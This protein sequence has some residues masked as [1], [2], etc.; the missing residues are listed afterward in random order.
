MDIFP[1][2]LTATAAVLMLLP[3]A[4]PGQPASNLIPLRPLE[5][6][7]LVVKAPNGT[8][9]VA[10][11]NGRGIDGF[12]LSQHDHLIASPSIAVAP[13][14]TI[15]VAFLEQHRTTYANAIY[16]RSSADGGKTWTE[17][18][19]LTEDSVNMDVG[20]CQ[21][22][23]DAKNRVYVIWR[24]AVQGSF[25]VA[26]DL[27]GS[28]SSLWYRVLEAGKWS[29][30]KP[31]SE[32]GTGNVSYADAAYSFF[33][34]V[35]EA[36]RVQVVW[37]VVPDKRHPELARNGHSNGVGNGLVL[38]STLDGATASAPR[39]VFMAAVTPPANAWA[40]FSCDGLDTL[41]GYVDSEGAAHFV[42][43]AAMPMYGLPQHPARYELIEKGKA[44]ESI[45]LPPLSFHAAKDIPTLLLD[46]KGKRHLIAFYAAGEHPNI[47][48]YPLGSEDEPTVIRAAAGLDG[49][50]DGFQACQGSGGRMVAI[51]QMN[52]TGER[53]TDENYVS[54]STG[55]GKWSVP[56]NVSNN[57]GRKTYISRDTSA[58]S[59]ISQ[60]TG[61][62]PGPGAAAF[63][64]DGH[65]LLVMIKQ[66]F[67]IVHSVAFGV[68]LGGGGSITPTLR[69]LRF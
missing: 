40:V 31:I 23:V 66:E 67:A 53:S 63:D 8:F 44:G 9:T 56:V 55:E 37:N 60:E 30:A 57:S 69:F 58:Q 43:L 29:K 38:Q 32:P 26:P 7:S 46:A 10:D 12:K 3:Q 48:D 64:A 41:N 2:L 62:K 5:Q 25:S 14:G 36:G 59:Q 1:Q 6:S 4:S 50:I 20:R 68:N 22:L 21:V 28:P 24:A 11:K 49:V 17:A 45:E 61:C 15:H 54:I 18:K 27:A 19:N 65:L 13:D 35:D 42:A 16:H 33:A 34:A 51:M 47:R 39:E 52:D